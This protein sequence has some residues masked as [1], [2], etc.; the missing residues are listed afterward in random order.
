[1]D[2]RPS[3]KKLE[4]FSFSGER[5]E[6]AQIKKLKKEHEAFEKIKSLKKGKHS[7]PN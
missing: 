2:R 6:A 3:D 1:M 5:K 7:T 4:W